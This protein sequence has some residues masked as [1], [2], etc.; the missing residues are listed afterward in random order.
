MSESEE[1]ENSEFDN[2]DTDSSEASL[3]RI[4]QRPNFSAKNRE[5]VTWVGNPTFRDNTKHR[6]YYK[7]ANIAGVEITVGEYLYIELSSSSTSRPQI[8]KIQY[9]FESKGRQMFHGN[10]LCKGSETVLGE[11]ADLREL[12]IL[13]EC[14][15][16]PFSAI[17]SK[18]RVVKV[19][20][21]NWAEFGKKKIL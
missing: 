6:T 16:I 7:T 18:A 21:P 11:T 8:A 3:P 5:N 17:V 20:V 4:I 10:W 2:I 1:I 14:D 15:D 19:E 13:S 9:M 12:F